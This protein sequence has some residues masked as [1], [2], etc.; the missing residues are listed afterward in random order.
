M[1]AS[2]VESVLASDLPP[3][4]DIATDRLLAS[5][6][7]IRELPTDLHD[8]VVHAVAEATTLVFAIGAPILFAAFVV[9]IFIPELPLRTWSVAAREEQRVPAGDAAEAEGAMP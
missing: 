1:L 3:G 7:Q 9:A 8:A 5:P 4:A 2:R 6:E